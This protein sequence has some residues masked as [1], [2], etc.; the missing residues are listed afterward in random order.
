M[1]VRHSKMNSNSQM[2]DDV[3]PKRSTDGA[4]TVDVYG[5][6][7]GLWIALGLTILHIRELLTRR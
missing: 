2:S 1:A 3:I 7:L 4:A 5:I 6:P